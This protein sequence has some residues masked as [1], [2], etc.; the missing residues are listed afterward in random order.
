MHDVPFVSQLDNVFPEY[1]C[2]LA[3]LMMLLKFHGKRRRNPSY[4]KLAGELRAD[5]LPSEKGKWYGDDYGR[6]AYVDDICLWLLQRGFA[7]TAAD[8]KS[9]GNERTLF[10][11]L[12][13]APVMAT[14]W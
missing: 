13:D 5:K 6:G 8:R 2:R 1:G 9:R 12:S 10:G 7:F 3:C 4:K 14:G 11:A